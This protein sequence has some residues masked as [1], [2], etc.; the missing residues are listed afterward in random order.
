MAAP[1]KSKEL[2]IITRPAITIAD[3]VNDVRKIALLQ[4]IKSFG[5]ITEKALIYLVKNIQDKNVNLGYKFF[6]IAGSLSSK[7]L[8]EDII[9]LLYLGLLE[10]NPRNK[11][12]RVTSEGL[13][14]L[15]NH[16]S[17]LGENA[18][19]IPQLVEELRSKI[20]PIDAEQELSFK[21]LRIFRRRRRR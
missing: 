14:F 21:L 15:E 16:V 4:T 11:K 3:I 17:K 9:A 7:E 18:E 5:E 13:E 19:K 1:G 12:L 6:E 2:K 20:I 10:T 8:K